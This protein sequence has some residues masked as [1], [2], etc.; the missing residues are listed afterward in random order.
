PNPPVGATIT[1]YVK[2]DYKSLKKQR[3]EAEKKLQDAK[4]DVLYPSYETLKKE[5]AEEE[6]YLLFAISDSE[7]RVVRKIKQPIKAGVHRVVWDFRTS[8]TGP[9]ALEP[10]PNPA[11]WDQPDVGYMVPPGS[12]Q[13]AMYRFQ[14]AKLTAL[15]PPRTVK[16]EPLQLGSI[17]LADQQTLRTFNEK[18]AAL[19]R[20]ISAAD[21]HRGKLNDM[22][23]Y[24]EA[25]VLSVRDLDGSQL[26]ELS[27]IRADLKKVNDELVG[28][29][30]L[31]RFEGQ[32]RTSL[33]GRT[34]LIIGSL[35]NTTSGSTG[36]YERAYQE[37]HDTFGA[38]LLELHDLHQR[39]QTLADQ[40]ERQG[41]P[42]T[43]GRMPVWEDAK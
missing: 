8:P 21:A 4:K 11:P 15:G 25:A 35:W 10:P 24:L 5:D 13:V 28:D 1:Y 29:K 36:T 42:Y 39:T 40:L 20:A 34:D 18:V 31:P 26:A 41:A 38:V 2:D 19:S 27:S 16:C 22:L 37:A 6:P 12:Y 9:I 23:P 3:N 33:K 14:D 43:P 30:L 32:A 17:P 7:G